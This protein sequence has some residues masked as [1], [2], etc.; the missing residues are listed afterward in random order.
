MSLARRVP[1]LDLGAPFM[2]GAV[3][4]GLLAASPMGVLRAT[5]WR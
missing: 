2:L 5:R 4:S 3:G 1:L